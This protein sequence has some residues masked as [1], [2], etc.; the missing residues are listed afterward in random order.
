MTFTCLMTVGLGTGLRCRPVVRNAILPFLILVALHT[1]LRSAQAEALGPTSRR[2]S[3]VISELHPTPAPRADGRDLEFVEVHNA[4]LIAEDLGGHRLSGDLDYTIPANTVVPAGGFLVVAPVPADLAAVHGLTGVLGG[5][6]RRLGRAGTL[7]LHNPAGAVLLEVTWSDLPP[8]PAAAAG[9]GSS[10]IL[11]R[12]SYGEGDPRA[13]SASVR[14][15]GS[16]G[17]PEPDPSHAHQGLLINEL[18]AHTDPPQVDFVE[19]FNAG[20]D[21]LN[22]GGCRL[23]DHPTRPGYTFSANVA[24]APGAFLAVTQADLGFALN[25]AGES[26]LLLGPDSARLIDAVAF[27][28]QAPGVALGRYP[29]GA[30]ASGW[31]ELGEPTPGGPNHPLLERP[32]VLTEIFYHPP[33]ENPAAEF[34]EIH[35]R[36]AAPVDVSGW[37]FVDGIDFEFPAGTVLAPGA[38]LAI[39]RDRQVLLASHP[40]LSPTRVVG[41]FSGSL[42][43]RGERLALAMPE[44]IVS[45]NASGA[46]ITNL[47]HVVV[48]EVTYGDGGEWGRWA[49]GGGSSLELRDTRADRR[50]AAHWADSDESAKAPW[51]TIEATGTLEQGVGAIDQLQLLAL[52]AGEYL[53]DDVEVLGTSGQAIGNPGFDNGLSGWTA[54]GTQDGSRWSATGGVTSPGCLQVVAV[55]RGDTGANR[56]E[57]SLPNALASGT[58][59]TLRARVRWLRGHPEYLLRLRGNFLEAAGPLRLPANLGT[60]GAPNSRA[61]A[62]A[63]PAITDLGQSPI[64]PFAGQPVDI[65]V[66]LLDP[67]GL[68]R[69]VVRYRLDPGTTTT[70]VPLLDDGRDSDLRAGDGIYSAQIPGHAAQRIVAYRVLATDAAP[71]PAST[72]WPA[73]EAL[74]R[75]GES[76]PPAGL[77]T[78]R[79][80][81][82]QATFNR[83]TSRPKLDNAPLPVTFVYND[84]R[85]VHGVGALYAGS[86]HISPGYSNPSGNLCGYTLIFPADQRF[87]GARDVVLDWPGRDATAQQEPM[88]YWIAREL[89]IPFNHRRYIRLHVNGT[90]ETSRGSIYE[91]AQQVNSDLVESWNPDASG[92]GDLHKIEQ[93]FEFNDSLG[94]TQVGPPRLESYTNADGSRRLARYRW[95]WLKRA[96][97]T[98]A[99][100]FQTLYNLVDAANTSQAYPRQLF[101]LAD[102]EEWMRIFATENIVVNLDAWGYDIGK[103]MYAYLP[104]GGRWQLHMWD[105][106]WVMLASAQHGYSP[107]SPLM[108]RGASPF[109]DSNRDPV[110]GR[111]YA[112]PA[113]QRAYWRAIEDAVNGPLLASR[114]AARMDATHAALVA[115]GVTRSSGSTLTAPIAVKTWLAQ[116]RDFLVQQLAGVASPFSLAPVPSTVSGTNLVRLSGTAPIAVATLQVQGVPLAVTWT[117]VS[118]W[119]A[120]AVLQPGMNSLTVVGLGRTGAEVPGARATVS[121]RFDGPLDPPASVVM[122]HEIQ[123]RPAVPGAEFVELHN[124]STSTAFDLGGWQLEGTGLTFPAGTLLSPGG[125]VLAASDRQAFARA[126]GAGATADAL[127]PGRL[128]PDGETLVLARPDPDPDPDSNRVPETVDRVDFGPMPPWP[129]GPAGSGTS[130]QLLAPTLD[131]RRPG[132]WAVFTNHATPRPQTLVP[133]TASWRYDTTGIDRG[134]AWKEPGFDAT[135]WPEGGA[136]LYNESSSLPGPK[137]TLLPLGPITFRFR[138]RF[139]FDADPAG[140]ALAL[141]TILDDGAIVYLNG[142]EV[143]RLGMPESGPITPAT[144]A[145]RNVSD[146]IQ[147]GPFPI[148]VSA[149]RRGENVLAAE[150]HQIAAGSS[151]IAFGLALATAPVTTD[152]RATPG[153]STPPPGDGTQPPAL[154]ALWINELQPDNRSGPRDGRG[155]REPWVE[156]LNTGSVPVDLA[157][158]SLT[159]TLS[160]PGRWTFP[161][162]TTLAAGTRLL[163]W[164][165]ADAAATTVNPLELHA[166][167]RSPP[168][169]GNLALVQWIG[170]RPF[171]L[172][173][174]A[175]AAPGADRTIALI[176]DG[177]ADHRIVLSGA[178]PGVPNVT[179]SDVRQVRLNEW[180]ASNRSV[181]ADPADGDFDDWFELHNP[182]P[183]SVDLAGCGLSD[184]PAQPA[185][186]IVP[187]GAII[188]ARG[189]LLVW[190]DEETS[191]TTN[192]P[193]GALHVNF[194]LGQ[195]GE[196]LR[197][198]APDGTL[199]D[200]VDF[201]PQTTDVSQGR[202]PD[203]GP[204]PLAPLRRPTPAAPN[205]GP[206]TPV[207]EVRLTGITLDGGG[208]L[209]VSWQSEPG[210]RYRLQ[211]VSDLADGA[212]Q[213]ITPDVTATAVETTIADPQPAVEPHRFYRVVVA[214]P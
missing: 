206:D 170:G 53:V 95:N 14:V 199:I 203:A 16:P 100:D 171:V 72:L 57:C 187:P 106:D 85:I 81:M 4:G 190:A 152:R 56:I 179:A 11:S 64:L 196:S 9:A 23:T 71:I 157:S 197:L 166:A 207:T 104:P 94:T 1:V 2:T 186:F 113:I 79:L 147:E 188:P 44:S 126:H 211:A 37:R 142:T 212:W 200:H 127:F 202:W 10:L 134:A 102:L 89:G 42:A 210:A 182:G 68:A 49:D 21:I 32:V 59:A 78:Y 7:R 8:W 76:R 173:F 62:N 149:L 84:E 193:D 132:S 130:L 96:A 180:M 51:T 172:D 137:T 92:R 150:V 108:Y 109:G 133:M 82:T 29:D 19:L 87:L 66:R 33:D 39:A 141:T 158:C 139:T 163:V 151:D 69:A 88:A 122:L 38:Y 201:G 28:P 31:R 107:T 115:A 155:E 154:H 184:D 15:E 52:A 138:T 24:L 101:A 129:D 159:D 13:W 204:V 175:Y 123:H 3:W 80:W 70:D 25:A 77:G 111:M 63:G 98:S 145:T 40:G 30:S 48:E 75:W 110:V 112:N 46:S 136:L 167:F 183:T 45:T 86:P 20:T 34:V 93:W 36:G 165:D 156:I 174:I 208:R 198:T 73:E 18:L 160:E 43:D 90:T 194:R 146:A 41:N 185:K 47:V 181:L 83:W 177:D 91:D 12:P 178:T 17:G 164:L 148:P 121:V 61:I 195:S 168:D 140:I 58:T 26:I 50:L 191:Q 125:F 116:R 209:S 5:M 131:N 169:A 103:N 176:P 143:F 99:S 128:D 114:V 65:R 213:D 161:A 74:V 105:I 97:G 124:R 54:R 205:V 60:P 162:G 144:L 153:W 214:A 6:D 27:G 117:S 35:N 192:A 55:A 120:T 118:N 22:L 119:A 189:F 135:A 67:D